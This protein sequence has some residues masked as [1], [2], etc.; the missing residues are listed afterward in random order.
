MMIIIWLSFVTQ[1]E[2]LALTAWW[3]AAGVALGLGIRCP[4]KHVW[5]LALVV[6][7][8]TIPFALWAGRPLSLTILLSI[9]VGIEMIV[10]TLVLRGRQDVLPK[11]ATP[12]DI[13]RLLVAV[14]VSSVMYAALSAA[15]SLALGDPEGAWI[16]LITA[17]PK[18]AAGMMLLTPL[19][20]WHPRRPPQATKFETVIQVAIAGIVASVVFV[21]NYDSL[22]ISFLTFL[23]LVWAALRMPTRLM[24]TE[25][26]AIAV[27]ASL[28]SSLGSGPFA[29][30]PERAWS[31]DVLLQLF[32]LSVVVVFLALSLAVG[33]QRETLDRL[34]LSEELFRKI[35]DASVAGKLIVTQADGGWTVQRHNASAAATL[36]GLATGQTQLQALIGQEASESVSR[37]AE[38][39]VD[40]DAQ[41][42]VTTDARRVLYISVVPVNAD[43]KDRVLALQF[44]DVTEAARARR[45]DQRELELAGEAHRALQPGLLPHLAGWRTAAMSV[46]AKQVGGDFYDLRFHPPHVVMSLGDVMGKGMAAGMLAVATR[47]ALR[48]N[49][50]AMRPAEAITCAAGIL[51]GDLKRTNAFVTLASVHV[52]LSSGEYC[53]A[54]A[55]HGLHFI[56][57][58]C[59]G[60][61]EYFSSE[62]M[63]IGIGDGWHES[64]GVLYPGDVFLLVSDGVLDLWGADFEQLREGVERCARDNADDPQAFVEALCAG[65]D[66][67]TD[68]DDV[69]VVAL[70]RD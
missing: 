6:C 51:E 59:S 60:R 66:A 19:F 32:E 9:A 37:A 44:H 26:L 30:Q 43:G 58:G 14:T 3:P 64:S 70:K 63:P 54:D 16:R 39:L 46:P 45:L 50:F 8:I 57:R 49:N 52:D 12:R 11:L 18:H 23:P 10:G 25:I 21:L 15:T 13:G 36:P 27:I 41:L 24:L 65:A 7:L 28:G 47:T 35:F 5:A 40:G 69:T 17:A 4:R 42:T 48:A 20:M 55:G 38:S 34:H 2:S 33:Q 68:R 62:D 53:F 31:G 1:P 67:A 61:V 56:V 29:F 22:P